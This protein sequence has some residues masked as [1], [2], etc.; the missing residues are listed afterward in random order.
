MRK[1]GYRSVKSRGAR[2][3]VT[4]SDPRHLSVYPSCVYVVPIGTHLEELRDFRLTRR[5]VKRETDRVLTFTSG[6]ES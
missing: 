2:L 3:Q 4:R 1:G 5:E 6:R